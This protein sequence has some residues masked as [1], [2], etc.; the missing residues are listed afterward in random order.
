[1]LHLGF[2]IAEK[3]IQTLLMQVINFG[4][5]SDIALPTFSMWRYKDSKRG[6]ILWPFGLSDTRLEGIDSDFVSKQAATIRLKTTNNAAEMSLDM[7]QKALRYRYLVFAQEQGC[8]S[9]DL[10]VRDIHHA[11]T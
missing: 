2:A 10:S 11:R 4:T 3:Y 7:I 5:S 6:S 1:M 9:I 8:G